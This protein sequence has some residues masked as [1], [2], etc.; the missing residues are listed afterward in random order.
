[1]LNFEYRLFLCTSNKEEICEIEFNDITYTEYFPTA[2]FFNELEFSVPYYENG[3]ELRKDERFD[4]TKS[5]YFIFMQ[6]Y[7]DNALVK[8]EYFIIASPTVSYDHVAEKSVHCYSSQY[9]TFNKRILRSYEEVLPLYDASNPTDSNAG[10]LNHMLN[11]LYNT[12]TI[13]TIDSAYSNVI[14]TWS[15]SS[16]SF[17]D[18]IQKVQEELGCVFIFD[19]INNQISILNPVNLGVDS[20]IVISDSTYLK[21]ISSEN[22]IADLI[23]RLRVYGKNNI[24]IASQNATG[25]LFIDDFSY[26]LAN[27]YFSTSLVSAMNA[28]NALLATKEGVFAGYLSTLNSLRADLL[29]KQ[30]QLIALNTDLAIIQDDLD[31]IKN[32]SY[33]NTTD[34]NLRFSDQTN[35]QSQI[36]SKQSEINSINVS[37]NVVNMDINTLRNE[38]SYANNFTTAQLK[39][40][41]NYIFE[42]SLTVDT[43]EY[44][45][46]LYEYGKKYSEIKAQPIIELN[47]DLI[48]IFSTDDISKNK[49]VAGNYVYIDC[50]ELG[51]NYYLTRIVK[52]QHSFNGRLSITTSN[53]DKINNKLM[54]LSKHILAKSI[55]A[56]NILSVNKSDYLQYVT[57]KS[58]IIFDGDTINTFKNPIQAGTMTIYRRGFLGSDIGA[59]NGIMQYLGDKIIVS[60]DNMA[61][62][63]TILSARGLDLQRADKKAR[64]RIMPEYGI[65]IDKNLGTADTP[66]WTNTL[67]IDTNGNLKLNAY[68]QTISTIDGTLTSHASAISTNA[69]NIA[70]NVSSI[71]TTNSTVSGID[72][73]L[74]S[75]ELKITDSAIVSTV[76]SS[77]AYINDISGINSRISANTSSI[78]INASNIALKV[79]STDYNGNT[80]ASLI[81]Q[82]ATT[83]S[84]SASKID[85][86][87]YVT[88]SSLGS[89]GSTTIDGS[90]ITTGTI[91]AINI[92]G[93]TITGSTLKTAASGRRVEIGTNGL[94]RITLS[95]SLN[96]SSI[97][98]AEDQYFTIQSSASFQ[99][100]SS[101]EI[102]ISAPSLSLNSSSLGF[103][104]TTPVAKQTAS[105]LSTSATLLDTIN[106]L[107]GVMDKL[108]YYGLLSVS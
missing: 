81:N 21:S 83:V 71:S 36:A 29:I 18:V 90:R 78:A 85:L 27:G 57:E 102:I 35:K 1:M 93:S 99:I 46:L 17:S 47:P 67:Y 49:I 15:F 26:L 39:E 5:L 77:T 11:A 94:Q 44:E 9:M 16:N 23:T 62:Y 38:V 59:G 41:S 42:D 91:N 105:R 66:N 51:F 79:S 22:K 86:N 6:R 53:N 13:A 10:L 7:L 14:R 40:L 106:K 64:I 104:N 37:I 82:T 76:T 55:E 101:T 4:L 61:T 87:G 69:Q 24:T 33:S 103:F 96:S 2:N 43:I 58:Q 48:D 107:N 54:E 12:W 8:S 32:S 100:L 52:V 45:D 84:I 30:N 108:G 72:T 34:Y 25:Q 88:V 19:T 70:L 75:A 65:Q 92:N 63:N 3:W 95:N 97:I 31:I 20:D 50:P 74:N 28:Y 68:D 60:Q 98:S 56:S 73:R 89:G 80:I